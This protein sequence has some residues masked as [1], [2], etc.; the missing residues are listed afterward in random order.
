MLVISIIGI[1]STHAIARVAANSRY[2]Y[3][4]VYWIF[5]TAHF[6]VGAFL[7]M[8]F[9]TFF[10]DPWEIVSIVAG[11]GLLWEIIEY[12]MWESPVWRK[13]FLK[14]GTITL[15]DTLLDLVLDAAGAL[16]FVFLLLPHLR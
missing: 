10:D 2:S 4:R 8:F 7:A 11:I 3:A 14:K 6:L 13:K 5:E 9:S 12:F 16:F 1:G 15:P